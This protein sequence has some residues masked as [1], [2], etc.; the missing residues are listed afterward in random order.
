MK[1]EKPGRYF[2]QMPQAEGRVKLKKLETIIFFYVQL[3]IIEFLALNV[4]RTLANKY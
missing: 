4:H 3:K 2:W 1:A